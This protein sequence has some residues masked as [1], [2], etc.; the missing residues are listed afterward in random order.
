LL[1]VVGSLGIAV[2]SIRKRDHQPPAQRPILDLDAV[3]AN[4]D[5]NKF[6]IFC[7]SGNKSIA[8]YC[9]KCGKQIS[10]N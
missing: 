2:W 5:V 8:S 1:A 7:G 6:C 10:E 9:E 3:E 4:E